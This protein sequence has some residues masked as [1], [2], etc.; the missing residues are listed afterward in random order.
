MVSLT[1]A[2]GASIVR[3]GDRRPSAISIRRI[4]KS[5][6]VIRSRTAGRRRPLFSGDSGNADRGRHDAP[7][8]E[9]GKD[10]CRS[11]VGQRPHTVHRCCQQVILIRYGSRP[12]SKKTTRTS[13]S[14]VSGSCEASSIASPE[15][16]PPVMSNMARV[17]CTICTPSERW[18][19]ARCAAFPGGRRA[20]LPGSCKAAAPA[21]T[22]SVHAPPIPAA[23]AT[24]PVMPEVS[25]RDG[26]RTRRTISSTNTRAQAR[27]RWQRSRRSLI[28]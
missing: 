27:C 11:N 21:A 25:T 14:R 15:K 5:S 6:G 16:A 26:N 7:E 18:R 9:K 1:I 23:T 19:D 17:A 22:S 24:W 10:R 4:S 13:S 2:T 8:R 20:D 12:S 3:G 28:R